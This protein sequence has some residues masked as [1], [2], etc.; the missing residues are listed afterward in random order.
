MSL[1]A[2]IESDTYDRRVFS[3]LLLGAPSLQ[4]LIRTGERL[5]P[6]FQAFLQDLFCILFK[7][8][9]VFLREEAASPSAEFQRWFLKTLSE[10]NA[11]EALREQTILDEVKSGVALL[12]LADLAIGLAKSEIVLNRDELLQTWEM[13]HLEEAK[14]KTEAER[15]EIEKTLA[16]NNLSPDSERKLGRLKETLSQEEKGLGWSLKGKARKLRQSLEAVSPEASKRMQLKTLETAKRL[17]NLNEDLERWQQVFPESDCSL[18]RKLE[19]SKKLAGNQK[20]M[21]LALMVGRLRDHA[22]ALRR[23]V[24]ERATEEIYD[25]AQG[26]DLARLIPSELVLLKKNT[27]RKEFSRRFVDHKLLQYEIKGMREQGRGPLVVCVDVSSSMSGEKEIWAKAI[28]LSLMDIA[29][30]QKRA[31]RTICFSSQD[32]ELWSLDATPSD[33][34][35]SSLDRIVE[36]AEYFPG[37]GTDFQ[38]PLE[39]GVKCLNESRF[40]RGDLVLITDGEADVASEWAD[41]FLKKKKELGFFLYSILIDVGVTSRHSLANLSD[42]IT[43]VS[44]LTE[45]SVRDLFIHI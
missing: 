29:R 30:R 19:I 2:W 42:R 35:Q 34:P 43:A 45:E 1:G 9:I 25:I 8:N 12:L 23:R 21:R 44:L 14:E 6:H 40:K 33:P 18:S 28:A 3:D 5:I 26:G 15:G 10:T 20:F 16:R 36:L 32:Q 24:L 7:Y 41:E 11:V 4:E 31:F 13:Q 17:E 22:R 37:G 38:N 39:M 27:L